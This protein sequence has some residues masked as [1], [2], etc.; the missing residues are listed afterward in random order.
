MENTSKFPR[1]KFVGVKVS[2]TENRNYESYWLS[3]ISELDKVRHL[4]RFDCIKAA[5][6][7]YFKEPSEWMT[8]RFA[9]TEVIAKAVKKHEYDYVCYRAHQTNI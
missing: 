4:K 2:T 8:L 9:D 3:D 1:H 5:I 6:E 7:E